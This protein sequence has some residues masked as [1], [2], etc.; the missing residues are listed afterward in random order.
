MSE[1]RPRPT[2]ERTLWEGA[3][4]NKAGLA[5]GMLRRAVS[6]RFGDALSP[7]VARLVA[8]VGGPG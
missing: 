2:F 5:S 7:P 4:F 8:L 6:I 3:L 1:G